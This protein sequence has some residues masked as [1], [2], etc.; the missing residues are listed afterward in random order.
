MTIGVDVDITHA[1]GRPEGVVVRIDKLRLGIEGNLDR[2]TF[3]L[4]RNIGIGSGRGRADPDCVVQMLGQTH[5][6][7]HQAA[8]ATLDGQPGGG[9]LESGRPAM[10]RHD[11]R[12]VGGLRHNVKPA[13]LRSGLPQSPHRRP[14]GPSAAV[15]ED[16]QWEPEG[17]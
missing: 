11:D 3:V 13:R 14:C 1:D 5:Q 10:R 16:P 15:R 9:P 12:K 7:G 4:G 2:V 8:G 6:R 17:L